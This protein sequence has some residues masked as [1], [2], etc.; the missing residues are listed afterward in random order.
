[1]LNDHGAHGR[2]R[3][4]AGRLRA[5]QVAV[6]MIERGHIHVDATGG[7]DAIAEFVGPQDFGFKPGV[8]EEGW[9]IKPAAWTNNGRAGDEGGDIFTFRFT[10]RPY[11]AGYCCPKRLMFGR[12]VRE[13]GAGL[14]FNA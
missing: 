13:P 14:H 8:A 4:E 5:H 1:W 3:D 11:R 10:R 7:L 6:V 9:H 2:T 12:I